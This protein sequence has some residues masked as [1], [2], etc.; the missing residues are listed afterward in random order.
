MN[1]SSARVL[2]LDLCREEGFDLGVSGFAKL[3]DDDDFV[4][5]FIINR[6]ID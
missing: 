1:P 6:S 4:T 3:E 5:V 2:L